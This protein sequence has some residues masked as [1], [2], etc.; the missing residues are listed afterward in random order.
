MSGND[1]LMIVGCLV[2]GYGLVSM[3]L[4]KPGP[5]PAAPKAPPSGTSVDAPSPPREPV[6]P[7][8]SIVL[9]IA[10]DAN[11]DEIRDAYRR[12]ISQYHPDKVAALG[13]E[14]QE[15]AE[16]KSKDIG[17]AYQQAL[18]ERRAQA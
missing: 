11:V 3:L 6:P 18:M 8:W 14:L 10:R 13:R 17:I 2:I 4:R 16:A 15:L 9:E 12:L 1:I 5:P 7:H